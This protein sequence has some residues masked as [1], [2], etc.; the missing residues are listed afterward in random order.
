MRSGNYTITNQ[1]SAPVPFMAAETLYTAVNAYL[2]KIRSAF[3]KELHFVSVANAK[4]PEIVPRARVTECELRMHL[5]EMML[6]N[7]PEGFDD[8]PIPDDWQQRVGYRQRLLTADRKKKATAR[9]IA[10]R[11]RDG[12]KGGR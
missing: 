4:D 1:H 10:R 9:R 11:L 7:I 8:V 12:E 2:V 3:E 6:E 5:I